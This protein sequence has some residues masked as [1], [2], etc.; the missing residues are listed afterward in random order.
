MESDVANNRSIRIY[1]LQRLPEHSSEDGLC[2]L[3]PDTDRAYALGI[4]ISISILLIAGGVVEVDMTIAILKLI[5]TQFLRIIIEHP[6]HLS[7][8][9]RRRSPHGPVRRLIRRYVCHPRINEAARR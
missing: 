2:R 7:I 8:N 6:C 3:M 9:C 1:G 5:P 4:H